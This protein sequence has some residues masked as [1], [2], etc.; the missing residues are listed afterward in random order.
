MELYST[1]LLFR[2]HRSNEKCSNMSCAPSRSNHRIV[3]DD[4]K[5]D[6]AGEPI[7]ALSL[8][9]C[10]HFAVAIFSAP[11]RRFWGCYQPPTR[12]SLAPMPSNTAS[13]TRTE[14]RA[15]ENRYSVQIFENG[16]KCEVC[17][18][19][20]HHTSASS[21]SQRPAVEQLH[22]EA[23]LCYLMTARK[24]TLSNC[25]MSRLLHSSFS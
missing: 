1:L 9:L 15:A 12:P 2:I 17:S 19:F 22:A 4:G 5:S 21:L 11:T 7:F 8:R 20:R 10:K 23:E 6:I 18:S 16:V 24:W 25:S 14:G 13:W 3:R